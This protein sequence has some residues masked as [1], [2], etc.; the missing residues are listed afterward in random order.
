MSGADLD[1]RHV[2]KGA[3]EAVAAWVREQGGVMPAQLNRMVEEIARNGG[4]PLVV[5][6]GD[7]ALGVAHLKDVV[8]GASGSASSSCGAWASAPS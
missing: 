4:T 6:E 3:A 2:R 5:A 8:K 1:G 7:R